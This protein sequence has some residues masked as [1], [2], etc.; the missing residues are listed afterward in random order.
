MLST[1][2]PQDVLLY[3]NFLTLF[4]N[5]LLVIYSV[6][7]DRN[8]RLLFKGV[9]TAQLDIAE[10]TERFVGFQKRDGMRVARA[11]KTNDT[12]LLSEL[13]NAAQKAPAAREPEQHK[14]MLRRMNKAR[15]MQ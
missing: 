12:D 1:A 3:V 9:E 6:R 10:L 2:Y 8:R 15:A 4:V 11:A 14:A 5:V 7:L 13:A